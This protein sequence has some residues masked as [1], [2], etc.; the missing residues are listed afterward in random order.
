MIILNIMNKSKG[1]LVTA[2]SNCPPYQNPFNLLLGTHGGWRAAT[3]HT[4]NM[5]PH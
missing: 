3:A 4:A 1:A 5:A 2:S